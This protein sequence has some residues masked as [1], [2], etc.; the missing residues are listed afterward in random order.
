M[1]S[2]MY[3]MQKRLNEEKGL[4]YYNF[5]SELCGLLGLE[6]KTGVT[7][8]GDDRGATDEDVI[9]AVRR[10]VEGGSLSSEKSQ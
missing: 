2:D 10:L 7:G 4:S 8:P 3:H 5:K 6:W 9:E 1:G